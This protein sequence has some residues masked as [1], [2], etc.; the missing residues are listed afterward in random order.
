MQNHSPYWFQGSVGCST[1]IVRECR[2]VQH[3][4]AGSASPADVSLSPTGKSEP[5]AVRP[6]RTD[7]LERV[8]LS[9]V[10]IHVRHVE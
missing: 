5:V 6:R 1:A 8:Y 10:L 2:A 4:H 7:S 3:H 9:T